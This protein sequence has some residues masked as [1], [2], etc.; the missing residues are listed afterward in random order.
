MAKT[1][2]L[3]GNGTVLTGLLPKPDMVVVDNTVLPYTLDEA[4]SYLSPA[5]RDIAEQIENL[6]TTAKPAG[7]ATAIFT[8]HPA[9]LS[10]WKMP[11]KAFEKAGL[12][13]LGSKSALVKPKKDARKKPPEGDQFTAELY[14]CGDREAFNNLLGLLWE[15]KITKE[16]DKDL[17]KIESIRFLS[18][19]ERLLRIE[20]QEEL[21]PIEL[22]VHAENVNNEVLLDA[23]DQHAAACGTTLS[24]NKLLAAPGMIFMP[25]MAPRAKLEDFAAFTALRAVRRL[26]SL[27]MH[28]PHLKQHLTTEKP[29]LPIK[30]A[31]NPD[32]KVAVFDGGLGI[33]DFSK[34]ASEVTPEALR[35]T[36]AGFL[37]HGTTVTSALLFGALDHETTQLPQPFFNVTH[38]RVLG[39]ADNGDFDLYDCMRRI[40]EIL[41]HN[42][43]DCANLSLGPEFPMDD[44]QPH[45]WT[46]MLDKH[47]SS[48]K[49]L[50][51][52]A[53][54]NNGHE[55]GEMGRL[56]PPGDAV[57]ALTV[58]AANS[59]DF[60]IA[61]APYSGFGPGRSPGVVKPDGLAFGGTASTP[62]VLFS[63]MV[64][65]LTSLYGTSYASPLA[66]RTAAAAQALSKTPLSAT[67]MRALMVHNANHAQKDLRSEVGWGQFP[68][69]HE[70]LLS[71][72]DNQVSVLYQGFIP[73]GDTMR[74]PLPIPAVAMGSK[75]TITAT[76]CFACPVEAAN[77]VNYTQHGLTV[78]F[79][80]KSDGSSLQFFGKASDYE[81]NL[82]K[83]GSK[84]ETMMHATLTLD[85]SLLLDS[86]FD[87]K[88]GAREDGL[89]VKNDEAPA[90]PYVLI[91][92]VASEL[93]EP[94]YQ[95]V[96][97]KY[98]MLAPIELRGQL[99]LRS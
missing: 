74:M 90:L 41:T 47:L 67:A 91:A 15:A 65:G 87:V 39:S 73:A 19:Q 12:R 45:A 88:H 42:E 8:I 56:Q 44:D 68:D 97:N 57:N 62:L 72:G 79:K 49:T 98:P 1:N 4:R 80:P 99:R 95:S 70:K 17:R 59:Q 93:G 27:R 60:F 11:H 35:E 48:G 33:S 81:K 46:V 13:V 63:P 24:R 38:Y 58:G 23:L 26:P 92:T 31:I 85:A 2:L 53:T 3:I 86:C 78:T 84:W 7:E 54:G 40:D 16:Q 66:L 55:N 71:Y 5:L 10:K 64:G 76:F 25:G 83:H 75:I 43:I 6:P 69:D 14:V 28:R 51:T 9:F 96:M 21:V 50:M 29:A 30:S 61:R 20:G 18:P 36:D 94:I 89:P 77:P 22:L 37:A 32:L 52:V 34:W 82:R